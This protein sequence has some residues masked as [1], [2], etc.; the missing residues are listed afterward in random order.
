[1]KESMRALGDMG[2]STGESKRDACVLL[3]EMQAI[4]S[5]DAEI[6]HGGKAGYYNVNCYLSWIFIDETLQRQM[7][8]LAC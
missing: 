3:S 5:N 2:T 7:F 1:M 6:M 8:Y 4:A